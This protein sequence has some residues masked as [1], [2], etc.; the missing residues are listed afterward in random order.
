VAVLEGARLAFV[1][2]DHHVAR[3]RRR[4]AP[5]AT[6]ARSGSR[7][8]RGRRIEGLDRRQVAGEALDLD[9]GEL[10]GAALGQDEVPTSRV[11]T[12]G[13]PWTQS[14]MSS[15]GSIGSY[16]A[17]VGSWIT[18]GADAVGEAHAA[19]RQAPRSLNSR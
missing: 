13:L 2:V 1:G 7:R 6:C 18:P 3:R 15:S 14:G 11:S 4:R 9:R 19:A 12:F 16:Q 5:A 10:A 17:P 8:R